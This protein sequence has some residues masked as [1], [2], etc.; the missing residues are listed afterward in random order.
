MQA[1]PSDGFHLLLEMAG[2]VICL[3]REGGGVVAGGKA[4]GSC[5]VPGKRGETSLEMSKEGTTLPGQGSWTW[6]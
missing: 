5:G 4:W 6:D 1:F 3:G 2:T